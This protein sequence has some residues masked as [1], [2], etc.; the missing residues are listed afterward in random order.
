[1]IK[2]QSSEYEYN[3]VIDILA[4]MVTSYLVKNKGNHSKVV[5]QEDDK[6]AN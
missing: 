1:M 4:E 2:E 5:K 6:N 3:I